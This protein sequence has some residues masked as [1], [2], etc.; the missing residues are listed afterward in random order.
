MKVLCEYAQGNNNGQI[1]CM[2]GVKTQPCKYQRYCTQK[3][4]WQ[5]TGAFSTCE[6]RNKMARNKS[7]PVLTNEDNMENLEVK[8][9][10]EIKNDTTNV[11]EVA[12]EGAVADVKEII[13]ETKN[14]SKNLLRG[15]V[16]SLGSTGVAVK[17]L[18]NNYFVEGV[19]ANIGDWIDFEPK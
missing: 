1:I 5:N 9:V 13:E 11:A 6:R 17:H 7:I 2:A 12:V 8:A 16:V 19:K 15:K 14:E 3:C 4:E 10:E 18:G